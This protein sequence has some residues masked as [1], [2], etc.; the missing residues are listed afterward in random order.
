MKAMLRR[1]LERAMRV[2]D[3]LRAHKTEDV[4]E[5]AA[6]VR[7]EELITRAEALAGQQLGGLIIERAAAAQRERVR[8]AL[9][10]KLLRYLA[11]VAAVAGKENVE[12]A[13]APAPTPRH[14]A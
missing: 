3:F 2:R 5:L 1:R 6:L 9:Q 13:A 14:A 4:A 7:L 8:R 10:M 12:L 11:R